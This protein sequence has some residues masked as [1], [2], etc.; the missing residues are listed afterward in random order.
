MSSDPSPLTRKQITDIDER[1]LTL[2]AITHGDGDTNDVDHLTR[3]LTR[4]ELIGL[5]ISCAALADPDRTVDELLAWL[6][7]PGITEGWTD[8]ELRAAHAA[9]RRGDKSPRVMEGSRIYN[10]IRMQRS[11]IS[12]IERQTA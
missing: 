3:N 8:T 2:V 4:T 5:A 12:S 6:P 7:D 10:R 9:R 1:A 11:R